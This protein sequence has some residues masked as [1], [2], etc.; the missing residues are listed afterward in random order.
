MQKKFSLKPQKNKIYKY[1]KS[2]ILSPISD[3]YV[4]W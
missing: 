3:I 4:C 1:L 2:T